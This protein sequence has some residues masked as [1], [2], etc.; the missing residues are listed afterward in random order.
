MLQVIQEFKVHL[1]LRA[2]Q[3]KAEMELQV[4]LGSQGQREFEVTLVS[5]GQAEWK[6]QLD[7]PGTVERQGP[8][9]RSETRGPLGS[10]D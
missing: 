3:V 4:T 1:V 6:E 2:T 8:W 7:L 5:W 10:L 9:E